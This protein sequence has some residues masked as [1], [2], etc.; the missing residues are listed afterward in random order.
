MSTLTKQTQDSVIG[1]NDDGA[2][3]FSDGDMDFSYSIEDEGFY[4]DACIPEEYGS[5]HGGLIL[6]REYVEM[7]RNYIDVYL[8]SK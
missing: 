3:E 1:Q 5:H 7:L 6:R 4:I 8:T 2:L